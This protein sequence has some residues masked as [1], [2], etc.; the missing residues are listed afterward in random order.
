MKTITKQIRSERRKDAEQRQEEYSKL[1]SQ[2]KLDQLPINGA[3]KQ[4]AK[5]EDQLKG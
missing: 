4:R 1:T 3:A 5:L 2:Q